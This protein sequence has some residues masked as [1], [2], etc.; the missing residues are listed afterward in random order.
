MRALRSTRRSHFGDAAPQPPLPTGPVLGSYFSCIELPQKMP[1]QKQ[2]PVSMQ[3]ENIIG[4]E[5]VAVA[6]WVDEK[7]G[8]T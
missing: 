7:E 4:A 2:I 1:D 5:F 3:M 6:E 8:I